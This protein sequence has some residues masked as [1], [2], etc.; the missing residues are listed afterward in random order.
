MKACNAEF[1]SADGVGKKRVGAGACAGQGWL[2]PP[3]SAGADARGSGGTTGRGV[4]DG[5][6]LEGVCRREWG[7]GC[8][9]VAG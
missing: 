4:T 9:Q 8:E 1:S 6:S 2:R 5:G 3:R 7:E